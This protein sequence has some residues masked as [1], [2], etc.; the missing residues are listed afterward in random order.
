[1]VYKSLRPCPNE[2][3]IWYM[4]DEC[5]CVFFVCLLQPERQ[6]KRLV[7]CWLSLNHFCLSYQSV[8]VFLS[9]LDGVFFFFL[10]MNACSYQGLRAVF[11]ED[12]E[13][14]VDS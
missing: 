11:C 5:V 4:D 9:S 7:T 12:T 1:M 10:K 6:R 2:D 14:T 3:G 8:L 13:L